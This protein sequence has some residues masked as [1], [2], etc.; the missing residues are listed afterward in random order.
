MDEVALSLVEVVDVEGGAG[1]EVLD[2]PGAGEAFD[3]G[4]FAGTEVA[5]EGDDGIFGK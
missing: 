5:V 4:C 1:D 3:E 2:V